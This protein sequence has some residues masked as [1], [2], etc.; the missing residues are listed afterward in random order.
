MDQQAC[1]VSFGRTCVPDKNIVEFH[2]V[3]DS[4]FGLKENHSSMTYNERDISLKEMDRGYAAGR[5][6]DYQ[7]LQPWAQKQH[8]MQTNSQS[9]A[10]MYCSKASCKVFSLFP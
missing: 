9:M 8:Y 4:G 2:I 1:A 6:R 5:D 3:S 10:A 7:L